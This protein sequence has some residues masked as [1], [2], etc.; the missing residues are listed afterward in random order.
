MSEAPMLEWRRCLGVVRERCRQALR[1]PNR[2]IRAGR[3]VAGR[4]PRDLFPLRRP[5]SRSL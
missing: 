3:T 2:V 1:R 5:N 4:N